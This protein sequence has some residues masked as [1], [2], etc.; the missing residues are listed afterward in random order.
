MVDGIFHS[1]HNSHKR[2]VSKNKNSTLV[3]VMTLVDWWKTS[4]RADLG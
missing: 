1:N 2:L 3:V 4:Q